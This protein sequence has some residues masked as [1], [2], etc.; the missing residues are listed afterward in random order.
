MPS[1]IS[2]EMLWK[3]E[4]LELNRWSYDQPVTEAVDELADQLK[5]SGKI[6]RITDQRKQAIRVVVVNLYLRWLE[7]PPGLV[8]YSRNSS[9]YSIPKRYNPAGIKYEPITR[10]IDGL[11]SLGYI[12]KTAT[13]YYARFAG[14]SGMSRMATR[15]KLI[16]FL[17]NI[18]G[19]DGSM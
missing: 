14:K 15:S 4:R 18:Y 5:R 11:C 3:A 19:V 8:A 16:K 17:E 13:G 7:D 12:D 10:V 2:K 9:Y 1:P 6:A